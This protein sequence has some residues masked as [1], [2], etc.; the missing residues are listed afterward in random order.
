MIHHRQAHTHLHTYGQRA[1]EKTQ[2]ERDLKLKKK[3]EAKEE[4]ER[5]EAMERSAG[6]KM[7]RERRGQGL[8]NE[9]FVGSQM[10]RVMKR[11]EPKLLFEEGGAPSSSASET[12]PQVR[13]Y[14]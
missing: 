14:V 6:E 1:I 4:L 8:V 9:Q 3:R 11:R 10:Q 12:L 5:A 2:Q 13:A 7:R